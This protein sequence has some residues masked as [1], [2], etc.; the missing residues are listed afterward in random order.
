MASSWSAHG[1]PDQG[2]RRPRVFVE[3]T[4]ARTGHVLGPSYLNKRLTR[5]GIDSICARWV[6]SRARRVACPCIGGVNHRRCVAQ[7]RGPVRIGR[8]HAECTA[9]I[10]ALSTAPIVALS[11][12]RRGPLIGAASARCRVQ[13]TRRRPGAADRRA[14]AEC[15]RSARRQAAQGPSLPPR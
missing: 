9:P 12:V 14:L 5:P 15:V 1:R 8:T 13:S 11:S 7:G 4:V 2:G 10:V 3:M 6:S